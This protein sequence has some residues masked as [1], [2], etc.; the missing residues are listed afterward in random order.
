MGGEVAS[1]AGVL[2]ERVADHFLNEEYIKESHGESQRFLHAKQY[3]SVCFNSY[4]P[5]IV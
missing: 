2:D 1:P 3:I 5:E 4:N